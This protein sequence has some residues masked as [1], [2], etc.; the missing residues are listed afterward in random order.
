M[1]VRITI[2]DDVAAQL[3]RVCSRTGRTFG[4]VVNETLRRGLQ[5]GPPSG[6]VRFRVATRDMGPLRP[7]L[8]IDR[9][10]KLIDAVEDPW[11]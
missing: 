1:Q 6:R 3:H 2:D 10:G 4:E 9:V 5:S 11:E 8:Q 7:G